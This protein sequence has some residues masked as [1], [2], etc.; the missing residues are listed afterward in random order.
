MTGGGRI[1]NCTSLDWASA[2]A[3]L[4]VA[5]PG[6]AM[7]LAATEAVTWF[8]APEVGRDDPFHCTTASDPKPLPLTVSVKAG[9]V[10][11]AE[12]GLSEVTTGDGPIS[13]L[14]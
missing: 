7:R 2:V 11:V 6:L 13:G 5:L 10:A 3:T 12:L 9:P 4:I 14:T 1:V 8:P